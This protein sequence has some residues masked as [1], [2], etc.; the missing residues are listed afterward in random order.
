ML[1]NTTFDAEV[2]AINKSYNDAYQDAKAQGRVDVDI[3]EFP[4]TM[5]RD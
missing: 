2:D 5:T 1:G 4:F 3:Y